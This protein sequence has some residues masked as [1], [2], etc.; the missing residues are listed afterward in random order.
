MSLRGADCARLLIRATKRLGVAKQLGGGVGIE[1]RPGVGTTVN[2]YLPRASGGRVSITDRPI[3]PRADL[4]T[5]EFRRAVV[6]V[7]DDDAQVRAA[8]AE[9]LRYAGHDVVK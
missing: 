9:M 4:Q 2:V 1:S 5:S 7:V 3:E 6:L 8:T